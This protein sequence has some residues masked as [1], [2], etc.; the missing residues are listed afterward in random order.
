[1]TILNEWNK[2]AVLFLEENGFVN[3]IREYTKTIIVDSDEVLVIALFVAKRSTYDSTYSILS[4]VWPITQKEKR[5][6]TFSINVCSFDISIFKK[7]VSNIDLLCKIALCEKTSCFYNMEFGTTFF[8]AS[9][10]RKYLP[11]EFYK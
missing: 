2:D 5:L 9:C 11:E 1:M 4:W 3:N 7:L 8:Y 6:D 10:C